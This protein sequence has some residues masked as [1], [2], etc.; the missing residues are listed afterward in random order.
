[1]EDIKYVSYHGQI[2]ILIEDKGAKS[3][4][5][6]IYYYMNSFDMS[7]FEGD[8]NTSELKPVNQ[9]DISDKSMIHRLKIYR[10]IHDCIFGFA[11]E[12]MELVHQFI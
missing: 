5:A 9:N 1:M 10:T 6:G 12:E 11:E 2:C 8:V 7:V 4:I 3:T